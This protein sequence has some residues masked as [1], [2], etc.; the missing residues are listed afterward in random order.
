[1][2]FVERNRPWFNQFGE[3]AKAKEREF[4]RRRHLHKKFGST[5]LF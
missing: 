5:G 2:D 3:A 1:M 4:E